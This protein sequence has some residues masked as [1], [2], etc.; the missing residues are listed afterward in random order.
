MQKKKRAGSHFAGVRTRGSPQ[1]DQAATLLCATD[2]F[3]SRPVALAVAG[4]GFAGKFALPI[5]GLFLQ[6]ERP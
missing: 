4:C 2:V 5:G 6:A 1:A 3:V